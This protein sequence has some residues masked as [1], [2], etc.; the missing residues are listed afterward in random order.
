[1]R[2]HLIL[3]A[4]ALLSA[5]LGAWAQVCRPDI[6]YI[7]PPVNA[8]LGQDVVRIAAVGDVLLHRPLQ[9]RG[10]GDNDGFRGIWRAAEPYFRA[11]DITY[12]NLE[13]PVAPGM[14]RGFNEVSDPGPVFDNR[15][16]S[17]YPMFNYHPRVV[18]ELKASGVDLVSTANNHALDRGSRGADLTIAS[19]D[20]AGMPYTGT[21]RAGGARDFVTYTK[22]RMGRIAWIACAFSTNGIPD[23]KHQ[24]LTCHGDRAELLALIGDQAA[25]GDVAAVIVTPH[26]GIE[27]THSPYR[28]ERDL[29]ADMVQAG[30][31][32][33]IGTHPHVIQPWDY[34]VAPGGSKSLVIYSTGNFVS[35]QVKLPRRTGLLAWIELCRA[36]P[37]RNLAT[38]LGARL[39]VRQA[40][41][42]PVMMSR[43]ANGPELQIV[44]VAAKGLAAQARNLVARLLPNP[45]LSAELKCTAAGK[46]AGPEI[47]LQ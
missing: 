24:V 9:R 47:L 8:C 37:S 22:T 6:K 16:Y 19:L 11:A 39:V 45:G 4:A 13:G 46:T 33:V 3:L 38:A 32:A 10:Y 1:M 27:Y 2:R 40:G 21:I 29:A 41:W 14:T 35:G 42:V 15:V 12:A 30:A 17:S 23:S 43:T 34:L 36:A 7:T 20:A 28:A 18:A 44:G 25:R 31:T 26:W 5:P